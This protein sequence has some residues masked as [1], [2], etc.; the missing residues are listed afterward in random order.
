M[1]AAALCCAA[2]PVSAQRFWLE[3]LYPL[4]YYSTIDG[5]WLTAYY[6]RWSPVGFKEQPEP[7]R[8]AW[9]LNAGWST[10]GSYY[11]IAD[12][13]APAW[14]DGWRVNLTAAAARANRQGYYGLGN[15]T[16]YFPDSIGPTRPYLYQVSRTTQSGRLTIQRRIAGGLRAVV[17]ASYAR[18]DFRALPGESQF[19]R[20]TANGTLNAAEL[21]FADLAVRLGAVLDLRDHEIDPH[22]GVFAEA[23]YTAGNNYERFTGIGRVYVQPLERF[24][25][26]ARLVGEEVQGPA[27]LSIQT[28]VETSERPID[29]L[30]GYR[31][32]R[33][34]YDMRFAGTGKLIAGVEARYALLWAPSIVEAKLVAFYEAGR[35]FA[36]GEAWRLTTDGLHPSSG[37]ELGVRLQRNTVIVT[38]FAVGDDGWRFLWSSGWS[39]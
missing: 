26:A 11:A 3:T 32:L 4:P 35:V 37:L 19:S 38:G 16:R 25:L 7:Y 13:Q 33:G 12:F 22:Q 20:D 39:F 5:F 14:W 23:L 6:G 24:F 30:G 36:P 8:A 1:L 2:A 21:P 34:Y 27:S 9:G 17:G 15:D 31:S 28:S 18:T 10:A 29:G